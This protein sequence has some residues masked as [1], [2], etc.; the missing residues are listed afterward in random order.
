M[1]NIFMYSERTGPE[2]VTVNK[3]VKEYRAPTDESV[4]LLREMENKAKEQ[5][6]KA[7]AV[8][9]NK[10]N[11]TIQ[12]WQDSISDSID[13]LVV[14]DLNNERLTAKHRIFMY[15]PKSVHEI[16]QEL[17]KAISDEI[18]RHLIKTSFPQTAVNLIGMH[19]R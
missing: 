17:L 6:I 3:T 16:V 18:A 11:C 2:F 19:F 8:V 13:V 12:V 9:D 4:K 15:Q 1:S 10:F 5:V 7:V 14:F